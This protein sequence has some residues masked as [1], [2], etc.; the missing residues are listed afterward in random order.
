MNISYKPLL[1]RRDPFDT[2]HS[3]IHEAARPLDVGDERVVHSALR[4]LGPGQHL[5]A[6]Q[7]INRRY[8]PMRALMPA[9][10][11][12]GLL[13]PARM[14]ERQGLSCWLMITGVA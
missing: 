6:E 8:L 13:T 7:A 14:P 1:R 2:P 12:S 9:T 10:V 4:T 5:A 3:I 11:L